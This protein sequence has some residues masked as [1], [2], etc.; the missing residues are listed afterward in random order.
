MIATRALVSALLLGLCCLAPGWAYAQRSLTDLYESPDTTWSLVAADAPYEVDKHRRL[1]DGGRHGPGCEHLRLRAP[2]GTFIYAATPIPPARIIEE[3]RP[4]LWVRADRPGIQLLARLVFP[5]AVDP[6]SGQP[7]TSYLRGSAYENVG[8]WQQLRFESLPMLLARQLRAVRLEHGAEVETREAYIDQLLLN[9]YGGPGVTNV[10]IDGLEVQGI[11]GR[12]TRLTATAAGMTTGGFETV[13]P[14]RVPIELSAGTLLIDGRPALP[15][16]VEHRGEP[17]GYLRQLGFN[18]VLTTAPPTIELL[19]EARQHGMWLVSPP[20]LSPDRAQEA[21]PGGGREISPR[22]DGVLA[23][24]LGLGLGLDQLPRVAGWADAVRIADRRLERPLICEATA[25]LLD[26]SRHVDLL[27]VRRGPLGTSLELTDYITWLRQ[28]PQLARAGTPTWATIQ[29]QLDTQLFRQLDM[30][31]GFASRGVPL[32]ASSEQ[33][34]LLTY[35]AVAAGARGLVFESQSRLDAEG[36][37][38]RQR[39]MTLELINLEL[40]LIEPWVAGGQLVTTV[41]GNAPQVEATLVGLNR[42]KLLVPLWVGRGAQFVPGQSAGRD[43]AFLV[44][45]VPESHRALLLRPGGLRPMPSP[46]VTGGKRVT[47]EEFAVAACAVLAAD[48]DP[49]ILGDL[50]SRAKASGDR[51]ARLERELAV[52][53]LEQVRGSLPG[54]DVA[55]RRQAAESQWLARAGERLAQCDALLAAGQSD[56]AYLEAR[57]AMHPIRLYERSQWLA[58][59]DAFGSPVTSPFAVTYATLPAHWAFVRMTGGGRWGANVIAAGDFEDLDRML[60]AGW[61]HFTR[62][63]PGLVSDA[64]LSPDGAHGGRYALRMRVSPS[65]PHHVPRLVETSSLWVTSS[66]VELPQGQWVRIRGWVR[67]PRPLS[68]SVDG[69]VIYDS[70][71]GPAGALRFGETSGWQEFTLVRAATGGGPLSVTFEMTGIGEAWIDDVSIEPLLPNTR[72]EAVPPGPARAAF[73]GSVPLR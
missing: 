41:Q 66:P 13:E 40:G 35:A 26:Y 7:V 52:A 53:E 2:G 11:V 44:P 72:P 71:G 64:G 28:R 46:R 29:T 59:I 31:P 67:I 14:R 50:Q 5:H 48:H 30:L 51:A 65:D 39:A 10:W 8:G 42:T 38:T 68:G 36:A 63:Q 49:Q 4:S 21:N 56:Q 9:V 37:V 45:G 15:R 70:A 55:A 33:I 18:G 73:A 27:L 20:P 6:A 61:R 54:L 47:F 23:W 16:I 57:R 12:E 43:V 60:A 22:F 17:L 1:A 24:N 19:D 69:L 3:L 34:R 32:S 25:G 58:A 62:A